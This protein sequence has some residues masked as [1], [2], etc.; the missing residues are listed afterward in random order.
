[1]RVLFV[2]P[3]PP[4]PDGIGTYTHAFA[5]A[6]RGQGHD[7]AVLLPR[8]TEDSPPE[9]IGAFAHGAGD[10]AALRDRVISWHPDVVHVQFAVAAFGARVVLLMRWLA[11]LRQARQ[12]P[13]VI[14][15]HEVIRE[16]GL[17]GVAGRMLY[18]RIAAASDAIIVHTSAAASA[19]TAR[20]GVPESK[21]KIIPHPSTQPPAAGA[22]PEDLRARFHL[23]DATI[24]LA[25][26]FIHVDKGL[27]DLVSA[28]GLLRDAE[29]V[30]LDDI[31]L[32]VAGAVRVRSGLFRAFEA[33]DR[34]Y[35]AWVMHR[36]HRLALS[37]NL[38]LTGYVPD[39]DVAAW[40]QAADAVVLPY[41]HAE[42][43][44]VAGL[45]SAFGVPVL[46]STAGGLGE[47][48]A[49]TAR[50]FPPRDPERLASVLAG[51]L[52][53]PAGWRPAVPPG[54]LASDLATVAAATF[55][56]YRTFGRALAGSPSH[57]S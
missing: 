16:T 56:L 46:A 50:T 39:P 6:A 32:V 57:V 7:V 41:R 28:L 31:R 29:R 21:V 54:Q 24:L 30:P 44:G 19:L 4:A 26:G 45:A 38:V 18:R 27:G 37:Q 36:A 43:S 34:L 9:V 47:Q 12:V 35:L 42:Q 33:W 23:G 13:I 14:T 20:M 17:L 25:F 3:Y 11:A 40:F 8:A 51:H 48:F 52:A 55:D 1:V 5:A 2:S 49:G 10:L 15:M 22:T 53:R